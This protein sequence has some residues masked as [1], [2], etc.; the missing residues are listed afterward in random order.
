MFPTNAGDGHATGV[1]DTLKSWAPILSLKPFR[2][3]ISFGWCYNAAFWGATRRENLH[4]RPQKPQKPPGQNDVN[5]PKVVLRSGIRSWVQRLEVGGWCIM[6]STP[7][8]VRPQ[9]RQIHHCFGGGRIGSIL[10]PWMSCALS[11]LCSSELAGRDMIRC[12]MY[13]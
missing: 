12:S 11:A 9:K 3:M 1:L 2:Q 10:C 8:E 6:C 4:K 7:L 13:T 5:T